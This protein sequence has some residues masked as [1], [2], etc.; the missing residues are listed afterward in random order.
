MNLSKI[1]TILKFA[2]AKVI[3]EVSS[4]LSLIQYYKRFVKVFVRL[5]RPLIAL[6]KEET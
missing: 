4:F 3:K 6:T 5:A 2:E 1:K